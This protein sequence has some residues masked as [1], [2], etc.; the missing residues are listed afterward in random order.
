ME[1]ILSLK[2]LLFFQRVFT[3]KSP[4]VQIN[5][6]NC[7]WS[8]IQCFEFGLLSVSPDVSVYFC[9]Q[10]LVFYLLCYWFQFLRLVSSSASIFFCNFFPENSSKKSC[11][12]VG[13]TLCLLHS[14]FTTAGS[15]SRLFPPVCHPR[16]FS[17][18]AFH[19]PAPQRYSSALAV[20]QPR[21]PTVIL[22]GCEPCI[23]PA[24]VSCDV[25]GPF[26]QTSVLVNPKTLVWSYPAHVAACRPCWA[27]ASWGRVSIWGQHLLN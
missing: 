18:I 13:S 20:E 15:L 8:E 17:L 16:H 21:E 22:R 11:F 23:V 4:L 27:Q 2:W 9:F 25:I 6:Y 1:K 19:S 24:R 12:H 5:Q 10:G 7:T 14:G 3:T 26:C